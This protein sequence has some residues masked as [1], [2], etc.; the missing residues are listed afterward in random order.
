M[1][2]RLIFY[3]YEQKL[4]SG[5]NPLIDLDEKPDWLWTLVLERDE[6]SEPALPITPV[7]GRNAFLE[8]IMHDWNWRNG[9]LRYNNGIPNS[10]VWLL[11]EYEE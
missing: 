11:L 4:F 7:H 3:P 10:G 9:K 2:Q 1:R 5:P 6:R 8:D